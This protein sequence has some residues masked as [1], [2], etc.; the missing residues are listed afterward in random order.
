MTMPQSKR[1]NATRGVTPA[2][3]VIAAGEDPGEFHVRDTIDS[4]GRLVRSRRIGRQSLGLG[5]EWIRILAGRSDV[6]FHPADGRFRDPTWTENPWYRRLGQ[7]YLAFCRAAEGLVDHEGA[8]WR[9]RERAKFAVELVTSALSPT[10]FLLG[11]PAALKRVLETG[12]RSLIAGSRNLLHDVRHNGGMPSQVDTT[13]FEVG[14]NLAAT[15]GAVVFRNDLL[16]IIQYRP[17]T[18]QVH[19]MPVLMI[20]PQINK[21]YFLDLAPGKSF[22]EYVTSNGI[23]PFIVS[24][25]NPG[26]QQSDWSL[27]TY[28]EALVEAIAAVRSIAGVERINAFGFCAGGITMSALLAHLEHTRRDWINAISYAVTLL[29]FSQPAMIGMLQAKPLLATAKSRSRR[30]GII[31]GKDLAILFSWFRPND[32]VWNYWVNNYLLGKSPPSF[33]I[34]AW[35]ADNTNLPGALH[36]DFLDIFATNALATPGEFEVLGTSVDLGSFRHDAF[37]TGAL[38]DHLTPWTGCYRTTQLLGGACE[39]V[40]SNAG[41]IASLVNPPGNPKATYFTGPKPGPDP[42]AWRTAATRHAGSWWEY[43]V[44]W[45][46]ARSGAQR[47]A[48]RAL[49]NRRYPPLA[50]APGTYIFG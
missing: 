8:D 3:E 7:G 17:S 26:P 22:V 37:V 32:L 47:K 25:R 4:L 21:Y 36:G 9:D 30:K 13:P 20:T 19:A 38:T 39:F 14:R 18:P 16:E 35:N 46:G 31:A 15:P 5:L 2:A 48:R 34:L 45:A 44:K 10:N 23:Q 40:L 6:T 49:G 27:D 50:D 41:H 42:E 29:D 43:W 24:W 11:N 33:D 12:G 1:K 28:C